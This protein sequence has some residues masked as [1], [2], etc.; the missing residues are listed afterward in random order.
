MIR[1]TS[2]DSQ[3]EWIHVRAPDG[4]LYELASRLPDTADFCIQAALPDRDRGLA[5]PRP[6]SVALD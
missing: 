6:R 3:W 5:M 1:P 2:R 4:N